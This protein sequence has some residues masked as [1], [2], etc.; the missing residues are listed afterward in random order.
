MRQLGSSRRKAR[1]LVVLGLAVSIA[2]SGFNAASARVSQGSPSPSVPGTVLVKFT[3]GTSGAERSRAN[4]G[5]G[6]TVVSSI[7]SLGVAK[8]HVASV[9]EALDGY[10]HNPVVDFAEPDFLADEESVTPNDPYYPTGSG[11]LLGG[12]WQHP[13]IQSPQAW[14]FTTGSSS[15]VTAVVDSG[16]DAAHPDLAGQVVAGNSVIGGATTDTHGHGEYVAGVISPNTNNGQGVAGACWTCR[17]MPVK[18]TTGST[19]AYSDMANGIVWAADHGARVINV[20]FG[21]TSS[22]STLNSAVSY[23]TS[24]GS[25]VVA[26]AGNSGCNCL[27]YPAASPGAI[28]VA[29]SDQKDNLMNYSNFGSWVQV[30]A[31]TSVTTTWLKDPSTGA[32]YGYGPVG[33]TSI[34]TP[35]VSGVLALMLSYKPTATVDELKNALFSTTDPITGL[36]QGGSAVSVK[37]GRINAYKAMLA[38]GASAPTPSPTASTSPS[39]SPSTSPSPSPSTSPSP[40]P[41]TQTTT[42]SGSLSRKATSKSFSL[43]MGTGLADAKLTF[44]KCSSLDLELKSFDGATIGSKSGASV[45]ILDQNVTAGAYTYVV[46]GGQCSFTL[47][48]TSAI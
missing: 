5:V 31:P 48:V 8:V 14:D 34:S 6:A 47:T 12:E 36:T 27:N 23:A 41:T 40:S 26:A 11:S 18:I 16:I 38:L 9:A 33:G 3:K 24:H 32:P 20:S 30:A 39:P 43:N 28:A 13:R 15:V 25:V 22:S 44:S 17:L 42:F 2:S 10:S 7:D 35:V 37:Y 1:Y 21:G 45:L 19:A 46:S 29:A 4:S